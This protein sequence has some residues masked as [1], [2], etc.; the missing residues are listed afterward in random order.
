MYKSFD[1]S[2]VVT[3]YMLQYL[4]GA[5]PVPGSQITVSAPSGILVLLIL[6]DDVQEGSVL[7]YTY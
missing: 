2:N 1:I 6:P 5:N 7:T 3:L 4:V